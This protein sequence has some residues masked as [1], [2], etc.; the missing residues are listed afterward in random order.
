MIK[1][2][3]MLRNSFPGLKNINVL[4]TDYFPDRSCVT[5][6]ALRKLTI[7]KT[8][9]KDIND[10]V[11]SRSQSF[12]SDSVELPELIPFNDS[13]A[14]TKSFD[15]SISPPTIT[16]PMYETADDN[17]VVADVEVEDNNGSVFDFKLIFV[18]VLLTLRWV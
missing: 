8:K 14:K 10:K 4:L 2:E 13:V 1:I 11:N 6:R 9:F 7:Y 5:I 12:Q 15:I 16:M 18:I 17:S 3:I